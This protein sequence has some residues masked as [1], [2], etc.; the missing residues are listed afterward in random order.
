MARAIPSTRRHR[1]LEIAPRQGMADGLI[2][3]AVHC[4]PIARPA[5]QRPHPVSRRSLP[6]PGIQQLA[7]Q[8]VVAIPLRILVEGD[9]E[10]VRRVGLFQQAIAMGAPGHGLA[11][12]PAQAGED[13][14]LE[15]EIPDVGRLPVEHL[16]REVGQ[17]VAVAAAEAGNESRGIPLAAHRQPCQL[18]AGYPAFGAFFQGSNLGLGQ[19]ERQPFVEQIRCFALTEPQVIGPQLRQPVVG[20]QPAQREGR[21]LT[22]DQ[23]EVQVFGPTGHQ[24]ID[25]LEDLRRVDGVK[26]VEHQEKPGA[27]PEN[28][29]EQARS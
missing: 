7:K 21:I 20:V 22:R 13:R 8:V 2:C 19:R 6:E 28:I 24:A 14:G 5:M 9:E 23:H 12:L 16:L 1:P 17:D 18:Q 3:L 10:Q 25:G 26:V 11:Q 15:K 29:V 27:R 4:Q